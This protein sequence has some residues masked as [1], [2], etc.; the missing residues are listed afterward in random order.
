MNKKPIW[1]NFVDNFG[2][3]YSRLLEEVI[4]DPD[5]M[6]QQLSFALQYAQIREL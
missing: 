6:W 4:A 3:R 1:I 5:Y 2:N